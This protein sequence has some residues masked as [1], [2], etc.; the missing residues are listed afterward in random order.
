MKLSAREILEEE[1]GKDF[2][3]KDLIGTSRPT[4]SQQQETI[5]KSSSYVSGPKD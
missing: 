1:Y 5:Q 3:V 2:N 4:L